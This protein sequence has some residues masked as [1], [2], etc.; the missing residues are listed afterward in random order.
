[1]EPVQPGLPFQSLFDSAPFSRLGLL[2]A[3]ATFATVQYCIECDVMPE[4]LQAVEVFKTVPAKLLE[5]PLDA[6]KAAFMAS[7]EIA[8]AFS[9]FDEYH[10]WY[11]GGGGVP[12]YGAANRWP[13]IASCMEDEVVQDGNHRLHSYIAAGHTTIPVL[14]YDCAVWWQAHR[15]W[16][17]TNQNGEQA[18]A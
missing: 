9:T 17:A 2:P 10:R 7:P 18:L 13:C 5:I 16:K 15:H 14:D 12:A 1:M 6:V 4:M 11:L 3:E 8:G